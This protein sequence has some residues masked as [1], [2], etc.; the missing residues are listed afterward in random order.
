VQDRAGTPP[1]NEGAERRPCFSISRVG[2]AAF[3]YAHHINGR[4]ERLVR[5]EAFVMTD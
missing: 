3:N 4:R 1:E 2:T 5:P